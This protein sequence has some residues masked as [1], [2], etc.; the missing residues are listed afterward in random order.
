VQIAPSFVWIQCPEVVR[1]RRRAHFPGERRQND[2]GTIAGHM[3]GSRRGAGS[4]HVAS[5]VGDFDGD[6][7]QDLLVGQFVPHLAALVT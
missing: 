1:I 4:G 5:F 7:V 2:I 3:P 6:G